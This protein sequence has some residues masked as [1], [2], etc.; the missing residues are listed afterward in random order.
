MTSADRAKAIKCCWPNNI[1]GDSD[2]KYSDLGGGSNYGLC[3]FS[4]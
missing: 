1:N 4:C 2:I 3:F